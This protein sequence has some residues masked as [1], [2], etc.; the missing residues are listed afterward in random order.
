MGKIAKEIHEQTGLTVY[1]ALGSVTGGEIQN[2]I[3]DFYEHGPVT[4]NVLWD[5]SFAELVELTAD[6]VR[7]ISRLP[8]QSLEKRAGGK[9]A[10]VAA[11]DLAY[12]L[13][14]M[15][16]SSS[17]REELPFEVKVF[18]DPGRA[19]KWLEEKNYRVH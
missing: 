11:K 8:R 15:Y 13:S 16:Q 10:I 1:T 12:G 5:I 3:R 4:R 17:Q 6:D 2:A 18:M 7:A 9:T 19:R 14:R